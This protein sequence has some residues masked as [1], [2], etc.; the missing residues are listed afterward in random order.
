MDNGIDKGFCLMYHKLSY[1]RKF[2]RTI[3]MTPFAILVI[4]IVTS[5]NPN[6]IYLFPIGYIKWS[7]PI[8]IIVC[9][10]ILVVLI[11]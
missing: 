5:L 3:W 1:R 7:Q 10:F 8:A 2:I 9:V 4:Y 6:S 11:S